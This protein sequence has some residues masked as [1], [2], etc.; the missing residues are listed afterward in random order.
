MKTPHGFPG[1]LAITYAMDYTKQTENKPCLI[2]I[3]ENLAYFIKF[4]II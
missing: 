2:L 4:K 3:I 1:I